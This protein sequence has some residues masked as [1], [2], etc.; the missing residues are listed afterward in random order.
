MPASAARGLQR[1]RRLSS[2]V[3]GAGGRAA[4]RAALAADEP[5][6]AQARLGV[7]ELLGRRLHE[8]ARGADERARDAAIERELGATHGIDD[9][10]G[11]VRRIPDLELH[12]T[13]DR[14]V[15]ER[16]TLHA[17]VAPLAV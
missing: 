6:R 15:A 4:A 14:H 17:D 2:A 16:R 13:V 3:A 9:D 12:L 1:A 7:G 11:R 8:I 10:A 5:Q